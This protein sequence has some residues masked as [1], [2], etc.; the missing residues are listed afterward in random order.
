MVGMALMELDI[1]EF[2]MLQPRECIYNSASS[3]NANDQPALTGF[4]NSFPQSAVRATPI[5]MISAQSHR[6]CTRI[7]I[8][9]NF[10]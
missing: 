9:S 2:E 3:P 7:P 4:V 1:A 6:Q 5:T 8:L 10:M